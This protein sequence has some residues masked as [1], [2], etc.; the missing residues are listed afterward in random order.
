MLYEG[1][2]A[3]WPATKMSFF[4]VDYVIFKYTFLKALRPASTSFAASRISSSRERTGW[5]T[6]FVWIVYMGL[7]LQIPLKALVG[8]QWVNAWSVM[9]AVYSCLFW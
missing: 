5:Y 6:W 1:F 9:S 7:I 2:L 4:A 8:S 3:M